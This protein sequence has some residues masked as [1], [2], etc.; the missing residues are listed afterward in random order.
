MRILIELFVSFDGSFNVGGGAMGGSLSRRPLLTDWRGL[1]LIPGSSL[2]GRL[3]H[4]CKQLAEGLGYE[5]CG[6]PRAEAMCPNTSAPDDI[7]PVCRLFGFTGRPSPL[8]FSDLS[9]V[10]P[11]FVT[12]GI[13]PPT[14]LRYGVGISRRRSVAADQLLYDTEVFMPGSPVT[15]RGEIGGRLA[16]ERDLGLLIA[17][18]ENTITLGGGKTAG[19]G[20]CDLN[21]IL[22]QIENDGRKTPLDP[23]DVKRRWLA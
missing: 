9:L 10:E 1:P 6:D 12:R 22:Y 23:A 8:T 3:R 15:L 19:L 14:S 11:D 18:L 16:A 20:W 21:F 4:T 13:P 17:G 5:T 7:C 2:K